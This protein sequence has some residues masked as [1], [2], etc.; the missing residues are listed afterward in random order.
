MVYGNDPN[1][2]YNNVSGFGSGDGWNTATGHDASKPPRGDSLAPKEVPQER[3][4]AWDPVQ[5]REVWRLP[6]TGVWNSGVVTTASGLVFEGT[7]DGK[8]IAVDADG[9][10]LIWQVNIGSGIIAPPISYEIDGKQY[11]SIATGWGGVMGLKSKFTEQIHPGRVYTFALDSNNAMPVFAKAGE[12][13][14]IDIP[15]T[16][17]P[18]QIQ[19]GALLFMQ[20]CTVCHG[21]GNGGGS[22][23]DLTYSSEGVHKIFKNIVLEGDL[24]SNGM[25]KFEGRLSEEDVK[26]IHNYILATAKAQIVKQKDNRINEMSK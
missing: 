8:L 26:D 12:K 24:L 10:K 22:I 13:K 4:I 15:F 25:P 9:G 2:K 14:L 11:I 5:Q 20:Y 18:E 3:L 1:W 16:S 19:H 7:A 17:T 6:L 23:P 21:L